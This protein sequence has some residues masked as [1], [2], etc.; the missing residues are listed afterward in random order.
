MP[1]NKFLLLPMRRLP[2]PP[3]VV[4]ASE[5]LGDD[6]DDWVIVLAFRIGAGRTELVAHLVCP[7]PDDY[8]LKWLGSIG[9]GLPLDEVPHRRLSSRVL[10]SAATTDLQHK[11]RQAIRQ[12]EAPIG[13]GGQGWMVPI[14]TTGDPERRPRGSRGTGDARLAQVAAR[15]VDLCLESRS[16]VKDLADELGLARNTASSYLF[17]ARERGLLTSD[18][19]GRPGGELTPVARGLLAEESRS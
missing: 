6:L 12:L 5:P 10:R 17:R 9:R 14:G 13:P 19:R 7:R 4:L 15:Y 1:E 8:T 3:D 2:H 11:A 18:E 16:P